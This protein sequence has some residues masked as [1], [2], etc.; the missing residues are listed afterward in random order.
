MKCTVREYF[1]SHISS[2]EVFCFVC[3]WLIG[4]LVGTLFALN[5]ED[6]YFS[7]LFD[8]SYHRA[9]MASLFLRLFLPF[10]LVAFAAKM[11]TNVLIYFLGAWKEFLFISATVSLSGAFGSADWLV[12]WLLQFSDILTLPFFLWFSLRCLRFGGNRK[13]DIAALVLWC[14]CVGSLDYYVIS[15]FL[16]GLIGN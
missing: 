1:A 2:K 15:P 5:A 9:S 13:W 16:A 12:R 4:T 14:V 7:M 6:T 8:A 11:G 10:L 3:F